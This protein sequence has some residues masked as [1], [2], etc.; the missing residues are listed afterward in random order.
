MSPPAAFRMLLA[1]ACAACAACAGPDAGPDPS[2]PAPDA[3]PQSTDDPQLPPQ[4]HAALS[5][6]LQAGHY[7][8]WA[9]EPAP[10]PARPPGAHGENRICSNA[11]LAASADGPYPVG[12]A[13]VKELYRSGAVA[14]YAVGVKIAAPAAGAS[15]YWYEAVGSSVIADGV[16]RSLCSGCHASSPRDYIF[17]RVQ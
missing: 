15:W 11:A 10:H 1:A 7:R 9:C 6:W 17:T 12:A 16:D 5:A 14:G 4:G 3:R 2:D 8:A 13:S